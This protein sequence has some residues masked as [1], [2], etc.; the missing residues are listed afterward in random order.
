MSNAGS[1][2]DPAK[3]S[4]DDLA[5]HLLRVLEEGRRAGTHKLVLLLALLQVITEESKRES[6]PVRESARPIV[7]QLWQQVSDFVPPG[8]AAPGPL[9]QMRPNGRGSFTFWDLTANARETSEALGLADLAEL[10]RE[11][12]DLVDR[13]ERDIVAAAI[14][15]PIP[16][17]Q[18]VGG[19]LI[20]F[21]Y[22]WPWDPDTSPRTVAR[23]QGRTDDEPHLELVDGADERV[24]E[25]EPVLRPVVEDQMVLDVAAYNN[26]HTST[27]AVRDHLFPSRRQAIPEPLRKALREVQRGRCAYCGVILERAHVDHFVPWAWRPNNAVENLVLADQGCNSAKSDRF[28]A[29]GHVETWLA[30]YK[31]RSHV[32]EE[33]GPD[34][35]GVF[36]DPLRSLA[37]ARHSYETLVPGQTWWRSKDRPPE[38]PPSHERSRVLALLDE[39]LTNHAQT[40]SASTDLP[41]AAE[42]RGDWDHR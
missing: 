23:A 32:G 2:R 33:L 5:R 3:A 1:A 16:R 11:R 40:Q 12:P 36:S 22:H 18:R 19:D 8:G 7:E 27:E 31:A 39:A 24:R 29:A 15:N 6:V 37:I 10:E 13:L 34:V 42:R 17:F 4:G 30:D 41:L 9:R 35:P 14:K 38:L 20:E 21:L 28:P 25:L 26:L